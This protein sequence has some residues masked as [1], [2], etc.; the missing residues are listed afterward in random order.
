M[1]LSE[2]HDN[3]LPAGAYQVVVRA[4]PIG[5]TEEEMVDYKRSDIPKTF[6]M[7]ST[8]PLEKTIGEGT[9]RVDLDL[10]DRK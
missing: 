6:W 2:G 9:N 10:S 4:S 7:K 5:E 3:G 8:N 1:H